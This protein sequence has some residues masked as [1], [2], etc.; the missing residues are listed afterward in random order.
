MK[1]VCLCVW[2]CMSG[3]RGYRAINHAVVPGVG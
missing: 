1:S 3:E 2:A